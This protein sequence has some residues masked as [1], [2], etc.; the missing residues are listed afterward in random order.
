MNNRVGQQVGNYRLVQLLGSGG[1]ADVYLG[2][3]VF[4]DSPAA[5]KLLHTNLAYGDIEGFRSEARTLVRLIHPNIIRIL[6]FGLESGTPFLVMDYAS[7]GTLRQRHQRG[8]QV[9]LTKAVEYVKQ[10]ASALQYAHDGKIIHRDIKPENMLLGRQNEILLSDFGIAVVAQSTR[11]Q[12]TQEM[13]G[14]IVYMAPEQIQAH[15]R[16]AS[17][18]YSLGVVVYEWLSGSPPF[19]GSFT[20]IAAKHMMVA[21]SPLCEKVPGL[22]PEVEKVILTALAK[23]PT[24]RFGSI[25]AFAT[26]LEQASKDSK[27]AFSAPTLYSQTPAVLAAPATPILPL[28]SPDAAQEVQLFEAPTLMNTSV[29]SNPAGKQTDPPAVLGSPNQ[30]YSPAAP[31]PQLP[32]YDPPESEPERKGMS[33]RA[34]IISGLSAL[35]VIVAGGITWEIVSHSSSATTRNTNDQT[36]AAKK[37]PAAT[38]ASPTTHTILGLLEQDTFQRPDQPLWG[39]ASDGNPWGGDASKSK[40]FS[41]SNHTGQIHRRANGQSLYTAVLGTTAHADAEVLVTAM[42]DS[43]NNSHIGAMLRYTDDNHYYKVRLDANSLNFVKRINAQQGPTIG[44]S[45]PYSPQPQ[46]LYTIRFRV[47][48]TTLQAKAWQAGTAEPA[49]WMI[50]AN[51]NDTTF[52]N[53]I[54]GLRPQLDQNV[55][56]NIT[57]FQETLAT[58]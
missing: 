24:Q 14:T 12:F 54:G 34:V 47:S 37:T 52:Q 15:P 13:T 2:K 55:I 5:I 41:I 48:G 58:S 38:T 27:T 36:P 6:D 8:E 26:A 22:S 29:A 18:Q 31:S 49:N 40:D 19:T 3:Q 20:E 45:I 7:N 1:F 17:D 43:F 42:L 23:D 25:R 32:V 4:L 39:I 30:Y 35:G 10:I 56:L 53:G 9:P 28:M 11:T 44:Q 46:T 51:D 33:R 16:P 50:T 21:P 57:K